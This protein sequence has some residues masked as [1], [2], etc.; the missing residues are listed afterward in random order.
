MA[1]NMNNAEL[2]FW[3]TDL[4]KGRNIYVLLS[5]DP[6]APSNSDPLIGVMETTALTENV[7]NVHNDLL[8]KYGRRY[9]ERLALV[10]PDA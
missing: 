6:N 3:R 5:N 8:E 4:N 2:R 9:P 7:V 10:K 1:V